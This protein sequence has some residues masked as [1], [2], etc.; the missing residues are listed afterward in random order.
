M[1]MHPL[2]IYE[3]GKRG[4]DEQLPEILVRESNLLCRSTITWMHLKDF[5][6]Q[7]GAMG[8]YSE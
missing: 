8:W 6:I 1:P 7:Q 2:A 3:S 5:I 4:F